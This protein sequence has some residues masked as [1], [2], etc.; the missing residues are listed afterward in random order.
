M[1]ERIF[2]DMYLK[3]TLSNVN[4]ITWEKGRDYLLAD[5]KKLGKEVERHCDVYGCEI[6]EE[7]HFECGFCGAKWKSNGKMPFCCEKAQWEYYITMLRTAKPDKMMEL[8]KLWKK[9]ELE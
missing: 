9:G 6:I 8:M 1:K 2:D 3:I 5:Y 4:F 7:T